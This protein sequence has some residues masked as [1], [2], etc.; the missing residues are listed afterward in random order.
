LCEFCGSDCLYKINVCF[1]SQI[2]ILRRY[3]ENIRVVFIIFLTVLLCHKW[4]LLK[5]RPFFFLQMRRG[6]VK[7]F[8]WKCLPESY[9]TWSLFTLMVW[10]LKIISLYVDLTSMN[11]LKVSKISA[12]V[13]DGAAKQLM[14]TLKCFVF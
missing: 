7:S 5:V 12:E 1:W 2:L 6:K 4:V 3:I 14:S 11:V 9:V 8:F 13:R 10:N